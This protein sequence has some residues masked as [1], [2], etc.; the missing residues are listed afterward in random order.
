MLLTKGG[1]WARFLRAGRPEPGRPARCG[2]SDA[3]TTRVRRNFY[4]IPDFVEEMPGLHRVGTG[5]RP[6][7]LYAGGHSVNSSCTHALWH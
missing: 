3:T 2:L 4:D 7:V 6:S 5:E 1:A